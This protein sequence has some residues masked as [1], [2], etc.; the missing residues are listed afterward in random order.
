MEGLRLLRW[1]Q[2]HGD[3]SERRSIGIRHSRLGDD[4]DVVRFRRAARDRRTGE[5]DERK[6]RKVSNG[7]N[8]QAAGTTGT[9]GDTFGFKK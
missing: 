8:R 7:A 4:H 5:G 3:E 2:P 1:R 9:G 6:E